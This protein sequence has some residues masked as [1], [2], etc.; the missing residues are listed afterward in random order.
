M[1]GIPVSQNGNRRRHLTHTGKSREIIPYFTVPGREELK[2]GRP[3]AESS[4]KKLNKKWKL[5]NAAVRTSD[6]PGRGINPLVWSRE[7]VVGG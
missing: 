2:K 6:R 1:W 4:L 7:R 5:Y 3:P